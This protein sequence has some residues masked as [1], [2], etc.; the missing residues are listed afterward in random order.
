MKIIAALLMMGTT[1]PALAFDFTVPEDLYLGGSYSAQQY[2]GNLTDRNLQTLGFTLGYKFN[3][4]LAVETRLNRGVSGYASFYDLPG[5]TIGD[6]R[7]QLGWQSIIAV[8][9]SYPIVSNLSV[10]G[11]VGYSKSELEIDLLSAYADPQS[12]QT[13]H[14]PARLSV[15]ENGVAYGLGFKLQTGKNM[16][17]YLDYQ[18]LPDF[19]PMNS[20]SFSWKAVTLGAN[21]YF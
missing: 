18:R 17:I 12:G 13:T 16:D 3:E 14:T 6:Y 20:I 8:K 15:T 7:E 11:L 9:G 21:Y 5:S 2:S 19:N 4:Y 1:A 10:Y